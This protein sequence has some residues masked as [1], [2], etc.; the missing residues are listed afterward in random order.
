MMIDIA[1]T[2]I[3]TMRV[4]DLFSIAVILSSATV[5]DPMVC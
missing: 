2:T 4:I 3:E 5:R 1:N